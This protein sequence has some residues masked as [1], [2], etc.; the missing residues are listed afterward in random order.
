MRTL[1]I[2]W[3]GLPAHVGVLSTLRTGGVSTGVY[4]DAQ[5]KGG[6]NLGTHVGDAPEAVLKNRA[7]LRSLLP[8]EPAW[9]EQVHGTQVVHAHHASLQKFVPRAD[10]STTTIGG[11]VCAI[12]TADCMPVLLT[13]A[14][15]VAVGAAHA[16]W[17][18][19]ASGVLEQSVKQLR[20]SGAEEILAW[21]GPG[22]G[23]ECFE[24]GQEVV[25]AFAHLGPAAKQAFVA[26]AN[27][28]GKYLG[29]LPMLARLVLAREGVHHVAG[30][31]RCTV[32][33]SAEFYSFRRDRI[34]G[35][36]ATMI[37]IK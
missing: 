23:P 37:W 18:G 16:G 15:G 27:K 2:H 13:D 5:G 10:A 14:R 24:V 29:N 3:P 28:P 20:E 34:T 4:A 21:L 12:M 9:L 6:L 30:G 8:N 26:I 11:A 19:L 1:E 33:E 32:S 22:I 35:R 25:D 31:D 36:M 17:R 7:L